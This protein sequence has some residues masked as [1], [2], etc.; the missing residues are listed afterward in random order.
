M[1]PKFHLFTSTESFVLKA[2]LAKKVLFWYLS[3]SSNTWTGLKE[4]MP[5]EV[6][7]A[8]GAVLGNEFWVLGG[9][10]NEGMKTAYTQVKN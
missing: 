1:P 6:A 7:Y 10:N 8:A 5:V 9:N 4:S 3:P 2:S